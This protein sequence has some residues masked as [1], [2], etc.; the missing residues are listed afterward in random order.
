MK[1]V[2]YASGFYRVSG[3]NYFANVKLDSKDK[4]WHAEIRRRDDGVLVRFAGIWNTK[5]DAVEEAKF[6]LERMN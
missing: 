6:I 5:K 2:K 4:K 1:I 3:E